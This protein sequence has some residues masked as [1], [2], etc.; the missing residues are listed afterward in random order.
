MPCHRCGRSGVS[1][2]CAACLRDRERDE[3]DPELYYDDCEESAD[4]D[5]DA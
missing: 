2:T 3:R 5:G 4:G 1:G